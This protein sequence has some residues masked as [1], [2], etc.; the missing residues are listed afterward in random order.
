MKNQEIGLKTEKIIV[1]KRTSG[2]VEDEMTEGVIAMK[3][4]IPRLFQTTLLQM[5]STA[6]KQRSTTSMKTS[7]IDGIKFMRLTRSLMLLAREIE[8]PTRVEIGVQL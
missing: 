3:I 2:E 4:D 6:K 1:G 7:L 8:P 5:I